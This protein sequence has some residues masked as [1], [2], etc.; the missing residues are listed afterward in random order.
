MSHTILSQKLKQYSAQ[1]SPSDHRTVLAYCCHLTF[2]DRQLRKREVDFVRALTDEF[3][4]DPQLPAA[5]ARKARRGRLKIM[6]PKSQAARLLLFH[7]ALESASI[8]GELDARERNAIDKLAGLLQVPNAV[9][10]AELAK[11]TTN[12]QDATAG[13]AP[14]AAKPV[15]AKPETP[16]E[17]KGFFAQIVDFLTSG[18]VVADLEA[19]LYPAGETPLPRRCGEIEFTR[20]KG[21]RAELEVELKRLP[22]NTPA[23][24]SVFIDG[25]HVCVVTPVGD[26]IDQTF[27]YASDQAVPSVAAGHIA[28][29]RHQGQVLFHGEF[30]LD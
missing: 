26:R 12:E 29:V 19:K 25:Q 24:L 18:V 15:V 1:C 7:V 5:L 2:A 13:N 4:V 8:D 30:H 9:V 3:G 16:A 22:P 20:T 28:E 10:D 27:T 17:P 11:L 6:M 21:G 23:P 14:P